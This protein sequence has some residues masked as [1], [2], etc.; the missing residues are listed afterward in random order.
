[1]SA[2]HPCREELRSQQ[3][4]LAGLVT[5]RVRV[6]SANV[7]SPKEKPVELVTLM[8]ASGQKEATVTKLSLKLAQN[9]PKSR[10]SRKLKPSVSDG[11]Q[12]DLVEFCVR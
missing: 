3:D 12:R 9:G 8:C 2:C 1:V 4:F 5:G 10:K 7:L 11:W 6:F